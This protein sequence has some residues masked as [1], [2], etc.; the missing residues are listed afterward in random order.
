MPPWARTRASL[1]R[2]SPTNQLARAFLQL[3]S[4]CRAFHPSPRPQFLETVISPAHALFE[5]IHSATGLPWAYTIPLTA[6]AIRT[7]AIL[8]L[9]IYTRRILQKQ[10]ELNLVIQAWL[11]KLKKDTMLEAGHLGPVRAN[12]VLQRKLRRKTAEIYGRW[13]CPRYKNYLVPLL[14][15]PIFF[16][17]LECLRMMSGFGSGLLSAIATSLGGDAIALVDAEKGLTSWFTP[18]LATEGALWFPDLT[19]P[20]PQLCL[21]FILSGSMLLD[22]MGWHRKGHTPSKMAIRVRRA[23]GVLALTVGPIFMNVPSSMLVYWISSSIFAKGQAF[24]LDWLMPLNTVTPCKPKRPL[25]I[26]S[27]MAPIERRTQFRGQ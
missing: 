10:S 5:G 19:K 21:S 9:S 13:G 4:S 25:R 3:P 16:T 27:S 23:V 12:V 6:L 2:H 22:L 7:V 14:Q 1:A 17:A 26:G 11:P 24:M 20:D 18:S 8:P 15:L